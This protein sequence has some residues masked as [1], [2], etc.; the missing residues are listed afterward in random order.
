MTELALVDEESRA[1]VRLVLE[2]ARLLDMGRLSEWLRL[3]AS[4]GIYT[5]PMT[6]T[7]DPVRTPSV[8]H[9]DPVARKQRVDRLLQGPAYAQLPA[10]RTVHQLSNIETT[11]AAD[12]GIVV[13]CVLV[14]H[15]VRPGITGL[16]QLG[17]ERT[18]AGRARY[19]LR[20]EGDALRIAEKRVEMI[21]SDVSVDNLTFIV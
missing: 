4:D 5:L 12:G 11:V 6:T 13:E 16:Q 15:E 19:R 1:A 9:D 17:R 10:S 7:E 8:L 2:E 3:F 14:I 20:R 21:S 18:L